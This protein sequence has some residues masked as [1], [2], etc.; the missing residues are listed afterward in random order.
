[1]IVNINSGKAL[2]IAGW[3]QANGA[4]A[5]QWTPGWQP[6]DGIQKNQAWAQVGP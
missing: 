5:R 4:I 3:S 2:E 6:N 1:M